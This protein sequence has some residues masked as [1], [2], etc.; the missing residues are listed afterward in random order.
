MVVPIKLE[1]FTDFSIKEN[2]DNM[3]QAVKEVEARLGGEYPLIINGERVRTDEKITSVNPAN[4]NEIIGV[5]TKA[6]KDIAE[7]A[8]TVADE[9]FE[10]W[11]NTDQKVRTDI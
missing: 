7:K 4:P 6:S 2:K 1:P 11:I 8:M 5:V 10:S 3:D 9:T